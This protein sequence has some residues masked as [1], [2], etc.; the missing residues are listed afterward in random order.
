MIRILF[1][2]LIG[3]FVGCGAGYAQTPNADLYASETLAD[4]ITAVGAGATDIDGAYY[5]M[6][7]HGWKNKNNRQI[8]D[9][10]REEGAKI[11]PANQG[12][13]DK[14]FADTLTATCDGKEMPVAMRAYFFDPDIKYDVNRGIRFMLDMM[15]FTERRQ[16]AASKIV[17]VMNVALKNGGGESEL[18]YVY[19]RAVEYDNVLVAEMARAAVNEFKKWPPADQAYAFQ[20]MASCDN[21]A[22]SADDKDIKYDKM[23]AVRFLLNMMAFYERRDENRVRCLLNVAAQNGARESELSYAYDRAVEY[24]N[25]VGTKVMRAILDELEQIKQKQ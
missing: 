3:I 4:A 23:S 8:I 9:Y 1:G 20:M 13:V 5:R 6:V 15:A 16:N 11:R 21:R 10:L 7:V 14:A 17:C 24:N 2:F 18:S 22:V 12:D 25:A 19:D